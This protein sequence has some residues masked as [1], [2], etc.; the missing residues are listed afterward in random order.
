[1]QEVSDAW[2]K[3]YQQTLIPETFVE[4]EL[5][6]AD[7][8]VTNV[9]TMGSYGEASF[10]NKETVVNTMSKPESD[11][12]VT[13]E[14]NKWTLNG[15]ST[16]IEDPNKY[17]APAFVS[18]TDGLVILQIE[19]PLRTKSIPGFTITWSSEYG[20]YAT[21][22]LI[23]VYGEGNLIASKSVENNTSVVSDIDLEVSNYDRVD[24]WVSAWSSPDSRKRIDRV[25]FGRI[26][27]FDKKQILSYS[28][29]Q[30]V[31][32]TSSELPMNKIEFSIDNTDGRWNMLNPTG[33]EKYLYE[34][35]RVLVHYGMDINGTTEWIKGGTFY[36][37]EWRIPSNGYEA[38][39]VARDVF[40]FMLNVE[41][42]YS[43]IRLV[44]NVEVA[45]YD[46]PSL[47]Y[48]E[49][50]DYIAEGDSVSILGEEE[51][52]YGTWYQTPFGWI[53]QEIIYSDDDKAVNNVY[54]RER[55]Y[56]DLAEEAFAVCDMPGDFQYVFPPDWGPNHHQYPAYTFRVYSGG[57]C[58]SA[59]L[60]QLSANATHKVIYQN[61]DG[62]LIVGGIGN[63]LRDY[64]ITLSNSYSYPEI[65]LE[66][67]IKRVE[68]SV[69]DSDGG[70]E[71]VDIFPT[72]EI[73]SV[74]NPFICYFL[75][76]KFVASAYKHVHRY[77]EIVSGEFRA[78]PRL[79]ALDIIQ[80]E[81]KYGT[82]SPVVITSVKYTYNGCFRATYTGRHLGITEV[83]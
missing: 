74:D 40:G 7:L 43:G 17:K 32:L 66:K 31:D 76:A 2:K 53:F 14:H 38:H 46:S 18:E 83:T 10:S 6:T 80:V 45:T 26:L 13:L 68:V 49:I 19:V 36:L 63:T 51:N 55:G 9:A 15:A 71:S 3:A 48:G 50:T 30:S 35:Q 67:P 58:S 37:C 72:G 57:S 62:V 65:E 54:K 41:Y 11:P 1:M 44:A 29:E 16:L 52:E 64:V 78:D 60:L 73:I 34:R 75:I 33:A 21:A 61:R 8:D 56:K 69:N 47:E 25:L 42:V 22:F 23:E 59:E 70:K 81:T 4:I 24:I 79:D 27:T 12:Y 28:H 39:F 82:I 5:Y 77:R 20:E